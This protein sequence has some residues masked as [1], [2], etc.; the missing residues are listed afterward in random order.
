MF[1]LAEAYEVMMGRFSRQLAPLFIQFT[2]VGE[3][4]VVL[5]VGCGTGALV[6]TLASMTHAAKIVGIDPSAGFIQAARGQITDPRVTIE[7]GDAQNLPYADGSFD[8]CLALLIVNFVPDA[9][10]AAKEMRRVTKRGGMVATTMWDRSR[11]NELQHCLWDAAIAIDPTVQPIEGRASYGSAEALSD[12]W[13]GVGLNDIEAT[14]LT[15]SCQFSSF[16]DLWQRYLGGSSA[17]PSGVYVAGLTEDRRE[18]VK[19]RLRQDVLGGGTDGPFT[20]QAKAWA[21]RGVVP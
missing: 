4:D 16:D 8:R 18:A 5:D 11:A 9:P 6:L 3:G 15:M 2:G 21:V 7:L 1:E 14:D 13:K 17:G 20:L 19:Q 10:K 12:L